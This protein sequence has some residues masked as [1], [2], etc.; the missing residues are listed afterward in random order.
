MATK[1]NILLTRDSFREGVFER[2]NHR[3]VICNEPAKDAH[4][5]LERRLFDDGGY[6]LDNGA[7]LCEK[8]HIA[9][10][11]TTLTCET[12]REAI[13]VIKPILPEH[14]Y[15]DERY[16]KWGNIVTSGGARRMKGEL[17]EDESVQKI[18]Q[19]GGVL[20]L[21]SKYVKY[22]RTYHLPWSDGLT[23]DDRRM[24]TIEHLRGKQ[25]VVNV[26]LDGENTTMYRD[27]IHARSLDSQTD[28]TRHWVINLH[29]QIKHEIP[30][31][32]RLSV[33]NLFAKHTIKYENAEWAKSKQ[34]A[35][36]FRIWDD[37]NNCLSWSDTKE[38]GELLGMPVCP[39][40]YEGEFNEAIIREL[41]QSEYQGDEM[42][43]Y[44]CWNAGSFHYRDYRRMVGKYVTRSFKERVANAHGHWRHVAIERNG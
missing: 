14:F 31:G 25:V 1:G 32:W 8:H 36:L 2:D 19:Q 10:E 23:K 30:D 17:F 22:P 27:Y 29:A 42:E 24:P 38:W 40:L 7:S 35:M 9:A 5:I 15:E 41:Y 37:K 3:C 12:I 6:Y 26:K 43:G 39:V 13:G 21:F 16:D 4:H 18:L 33:E 20:P 11:E 28:V 34:Y 44:V